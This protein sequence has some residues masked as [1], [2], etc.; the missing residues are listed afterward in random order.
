MRIALDTNV[1]VSAFATRGL[2]ADIFNLV[3]AEHEL[4][5]GGTVLAE[6]QR[7]LQEKLRVPAEI[8]QE[9]DEF[10]RREAVV[11][12]EAPALPV[13]IRD[14]SD[15]PVLAEAVAGRA[16]VLVAGDQDLLEIAGTVPI[17]IL[18]P[19]GL[20]TLLRTDIAPGQ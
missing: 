20:W 1:F 9:L 16:E 11:V 15:R 2:C 8:I 6:L 10:L 12:G 4:V 14:Q 18:T 13:T 19:R 5:V 17:R 3:L 7:V